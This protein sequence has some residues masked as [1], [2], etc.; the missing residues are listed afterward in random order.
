MYELL[1]VLTVGLGIYTVGIAVGVFL[2]WLFP[3]II[4]TRNRRR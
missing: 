3:K 2:A 4:R 1:N